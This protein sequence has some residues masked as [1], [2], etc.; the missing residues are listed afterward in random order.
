[1]QTRGISR[2]LY[3]LDDYLLRQAKSVLITFAGVHQL[4]TTYK[5]EGPTTSLTFLG[6]QLDSVTMQLSLAEDKLTRLVLS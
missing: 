5:T 3:Y 6:I 4:V 1:M 2:E